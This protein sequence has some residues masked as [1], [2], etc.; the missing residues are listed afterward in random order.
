MKN[1]YDQR[2]TSYSQSGGITAHT[3]TINPKFQRVMDNAMREGLL[4]LPREK[5]TVVY[6][7]FNDEEAFKFANEIFQFLKVSGFNLF[8]D[9]AQGNLFT[10]PVYGVTAIPYP[11]KT[12]ILIGWK[13]EK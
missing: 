4:S 11:D 7:S 3:V 2:V 9:A 13:S 1:V 10:Q 6:A 5:L 8:G 12:E